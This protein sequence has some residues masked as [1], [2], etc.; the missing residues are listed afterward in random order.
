MKKARA[1]LTLVNQTINWDHVPK[2]AP[3]KLKG[4]FEK[5]HSYAFVTGVSTGKEKIIGQDDYL[6]HQTTILARVRD[7]YRDAGF[8]TR[9]ILQ[10]P[11]THKGP[12]VACTI[13]FPTGL[14]QDLWTDSLRIFKR[15]VCR[16]HVDVASASNGDIWSIPH[17]EPDPIFHWKE[18]IEYSTVKHLELKGA[19]AVRILK[20]FLTL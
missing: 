14:P 4:A 13:G 1:R 11:R 20:H 5:P 12:T 6:D 17:V 8:A 18:H 19:P 3:I 2:L 10:D 16:I 15:F 9:V 7:Q